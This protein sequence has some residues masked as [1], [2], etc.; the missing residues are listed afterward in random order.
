MINVKINEA[1]Y[2]SITGEVFMQAAA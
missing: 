2:S 1:G